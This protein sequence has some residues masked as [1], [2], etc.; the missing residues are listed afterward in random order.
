MKLDLQIFGDTRFGHRLPEVPFSAKVSSEYCEK[1]G[2]DI[3]GRT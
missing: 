1:D 2:P 3:V